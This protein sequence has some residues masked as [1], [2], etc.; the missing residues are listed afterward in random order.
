MTD[1]LQ[2]M[3]DNGDRFNEL[4]IAYI[5]RE[6]MQVIIDIVINLSQYKKQQCVSWM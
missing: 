1:L 4:I 5:L 3:L 6:T 2:G